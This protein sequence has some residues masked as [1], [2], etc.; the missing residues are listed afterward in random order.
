MGYTDIQYSEAENI[1]LPDLLFCCSNI[2]N[3]VLKWYE[4]LAKSLHIPLVM[5]DMFLVA[6]LKTVGEDI[7]STNNTRGE[8]IEVLGVMPD[9]ESRFPEKQ[10]AVILPGSHTHILLAGHVKYAQLNLS[11]T[12]IG[13]DAGVALGKYGELRKIGRAVQQ[14][15]RDR[16]RMPS[17]A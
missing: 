17:S 6:G 8:E 11:E 10:I 14:E 13:L 2:C 4:N 15:C 12:N 1:P 9:L 7:S 5:F 16:S 3:T